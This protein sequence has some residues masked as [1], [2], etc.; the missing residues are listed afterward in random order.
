MRESDLCASSI[1]DQLVVFRG[2]RAPVLGDHVHDNCDRGPSVGGIHLLH[3]N[4]PLCASYRRP[5]QH[6]PLQLHWR[7][8]FALRIRPLPSF[9]FFCGNGEHSNPVCDAM[10]N[11]L[12]A[13]VVHLLPR[14]DYTG[15]SRRHDAQPSALERA[16]VGQLT[17][18]SLLQLVRVLSSAV[19][20]WRRRRSR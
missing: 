15:S 9:R 2:E 19:C 6:L 20:L 13:H 4:V 14:L 17:G 18:H 12:H 10:R 1:D 7:V 16:S 3:H 11:G 5:A 8:Q